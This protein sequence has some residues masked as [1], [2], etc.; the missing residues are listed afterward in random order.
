MAIRIM[1]TGQIRCD[2]CEQI[3]ANLEASQQVFDVIEQ[4][5]KHIRISCPC[6]FSDD[7]DDDIG[8]LQKQDDEDDN[9]KL[10]GKFEILHA[11]L[12][13]DEN[14]FLKVR[15]VDVVRMADGSIHPASKWCDRHRTKEHETNLKNY[16]K[17]RR[18]RDNKKPKKDGK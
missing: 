16:R 4:E 11:V 5:K 18:K 7:E 17:T 6:V 8:E 15:P 14:C 12:C 9:K 2:H 3:L 10:V 13:S 1:K